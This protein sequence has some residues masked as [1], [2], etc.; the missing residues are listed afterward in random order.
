M[1]PRLV[2]KFP[3]LMDGVIENSLNMVSFLVDLS[4]YMLGYLTE[5]PLLP[6]EMP[7][8]APGDFYKHPL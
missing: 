4:T 3:S 1:N 2:V 8:R 6:P 5:S 7:E